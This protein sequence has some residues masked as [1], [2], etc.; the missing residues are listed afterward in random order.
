MSRLASTATIYRE[1]DVQYGITK[2]QAALLL[3]AALMIASCN[4]FRD[5]AKVATDFCINDDN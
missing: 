5:A 2:L 1:S 4:K 3:V